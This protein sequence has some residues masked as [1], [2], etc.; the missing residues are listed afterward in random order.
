MK[1]ASWLSTDEPTQ[2]MRANVWSGFGGNAATM[3]GPDR[4]PLISHA[5]YMDIDF[6]TKINA[7][8]SAFSD[9]GYQFA[10]SHDGGGRPDGVKGTAGL[11][12]RW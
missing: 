5:Q 6:S 10:I 1:L 4:A 7:H 8:L 2:Y 11:R 3:F 9:A 12:F